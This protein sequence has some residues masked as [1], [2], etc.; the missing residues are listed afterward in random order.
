MNAE[1]VNKAEARFVWATIPA[2]LTPALQRIHADPAL[3]AEAMD[4]VLALGVE[5]LARLPEHE[6]RAPFN[7]CFALEH[8]AAEWLKHKERS[9]P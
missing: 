7:V 1:E 4:P 8:A 5:F 2:D 3:K 6:R 9:A